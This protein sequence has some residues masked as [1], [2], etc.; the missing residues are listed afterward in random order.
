MA[1]ASR[2]EPANRHRPAVEKLSAEKVQSLTSPPPKPA[3]LAGAPAGGSVAGQQL[4]SRLNF[5]TSKRAVMNR[6]MN[7]QVQIHRGQAPFQNWDWAEAARDRI[8]HSPEGEAL[9]LLRYVKLDLQNAGDFKVTPLDNLAEPRD[10]SQEELLK[11]NFI[12]VPLKAG[13]CRLWI[14]VLT[15]PAQEPFSNR[16][17]TVKVYKVTVIP[18][19]TWIRRAQ[20]AIEE[21]T[22]LM[23]ALS[24]LLAATASV[25]GYL[26]LKRFRKRRTSGKAAHTVPK[27]G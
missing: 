26:G 4:E 3:A 22:G 12:V 6:E 10:L 8:E 5:V 20:H 13:E 27:K 24:A 11:W 19:E 14:R 16:W 23:K 18:D 15:S 7:L 2:S 1:C 9:S 21:M 17:E 25:L